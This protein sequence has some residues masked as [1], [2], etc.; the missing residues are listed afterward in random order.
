MSYCPFVTQDFHTELMKNKFVA[1]INQK[2][3][4]MAKIGMGREH[5]KYYKHTKFCK[6]LRNGLKFL[7]L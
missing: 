3:V 6:N 4:H 2:L 7:K 1:V 5:H